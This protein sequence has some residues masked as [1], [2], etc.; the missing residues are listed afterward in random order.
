M[1]GE[2]RSYRSSLHTH[3]HFEVFCVD[4]FLSL[5]ILCNPPPQGSSILAYFIAFLL[6]KHPEDFG[7]HD[8]DGS[9]Q[10]RMQ[11]WK[12][13]TLGGKE[14]Q[15]GKTP[16]EIEGTAVAPQTARR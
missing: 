6:H 7:V 5:T 3:T 15:M 13:T 12:A 9:G 4:I 16:R 8:M 10:A 1:I 11:K 14:Y 2:K